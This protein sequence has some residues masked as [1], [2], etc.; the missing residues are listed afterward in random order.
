MNQTLKPIIDALS[1]I[2]NRRTRHFERL[3]FEMS[4]DTPVAGSF[5]AIDGSEQVAHIND[6]EFDAPS[7]FFMCKSIHIFSKAVIFDCIFPIR[8]KVNEAMFAEDAYNELCT[9]PVPEEID[10]VIISIDGKEYELV[11]FEDFNFE[12]D[13]VDNNKFAF[14]QS[15]VTKPLIE[16]DNTPWANEK[17]KEAWSIE[18]KTL[19]DIAVSPY[20]VEEDDDIDECDAGGAAGGCAGGDA[21]GAATGGDAGGGDAGGASTSGGDSA[22]G[23]TTTDVLGD[24][25]PA[26]GFMGNNFYLPFHV[27]HPLHRWEIANGGSKRKKTKSGK[28]KKYP[29][30]KGMKT[31][32]SMFED[33]MPINSPKVD[34]KKLKNKIRTI[35]SGVKSMSDVK[36]VEAKFSKNKKD[37]EKR[38][39]SNK[40]KEA[41]QIA[42]DFGM[43]LKDICT[44]KYKASWF[45]ISMVAAAIIYLLLPVDLI[46]D[47][48]PVIGQIDDAIVLWMV[49]KAIQ[50]EF[51]AW[52]QVNGLTVNEYESLNEGFGRKRTPI[53]EV[54]S[55]KL[56]DLAGIDDYQLV[57]DTFIEHMDNLDPKKVGKDL[58]KDWE[59][60]KKWKTYTP[61]FEELWA[62]W[63]AANKLP[64]PNT[65]E[66]GEVWYADKETA[67]DKWAYYLKGLDRSY[68][69]CLYA[70]GTKEIVK[71]KE[72]D[73]TKSYQNPKVIR[74]YIDLYGISRLNKEW[75]R[76]MQA[77]EQAKKG[78]EPIQMSTTKLS[79]PKDFTTYGVKKLRDGWHVFITDQRERDEALTVMD[80]AYKQKRNAEKVPPQQNERFG[81]R[82]IV[83]KSDGWHVTY[84]DMT[85][86]EPRIT[87]LKKSFNTKEAA[88]DEMIRIQARNRVIS[89]TAKPFEKNGKW[90][91]KFTDANTHRTVVLDD[92]YETEGKA[93]MAC[94]YIGEP[95]DID[96]DGIDDLGYIAM[97]QKLEDGYYIVQKYDLNNQDTIGPYDKK[98]DAEDAMKAIGLPEFKTVRIV[99]MHGNYY[100]M[101]ADERLHTKI[102]P[103]EGVNGKKLA[104]RFVRRNN[105]ELEK[106]KGDNY[107]EDFKKISLPW[108]LFTYKMD[109][110]EC[111]DITFAANEQGAMK[112]FQ[113]QYQ[114]FVGKIPSMDPFLGGI[115]DLEDSLKYLVGKKGITDIEMTE[116]PP[117]DEDALR[118]AVKTMKSFGNPFTHTDLQ[119]MK[120]NPKVKHHLMDGRQTYTTAHDFHSKY[121]RTVNN[122]KPSVDPK[123]TLEQKLD[124]AMFAANKK[125]KD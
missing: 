55:L 2:S 77:M 115:K 49:Y 113:S 83:K 7:I 88:L 120:I 110:K 74:N 125:K 64:A 54:K 86:T 9:I 92:E 1:T 94:R 25:D 52:K 103:F 51:N 4:I 34:K 114:E 66:H 105:M 65:E 38:L 67:P 118:E 73:P 6:Y 89:G 99:N 108:F 5:V 121:V 98:Q 87:I 62:R 109:G 57:Y 21:G 101:S 43:F 20:L 61:V 15:I 78:H 72:Q 11:S 104:E 122:Q 27:K 16:L 12:C 36:A 47:F 123:G 18:Q 63:Y 23:I 95:K 100:I 44:G 56:E 97:V 31:V 58:I 93:K 124:D 13:E 82:K 28:A 32:I 45:T 85:R 39:S 102:G 60:M 91:I 8:K 10:H 40:F 29:Y 37:V 69:Y 116:I 46:P 50:D 119:H 80:K 22:T 117:S 76:L 70:D 17:A 90:Y 35:A 24:Y 75:E 107:I 41:K 71:S 106:A 48:I 96:T 68:L 53:D 42:V 79:D 111:A 33:E 14:I 59:N 30:E 81:T 3:A 84:R 26:K 19:S 112:R